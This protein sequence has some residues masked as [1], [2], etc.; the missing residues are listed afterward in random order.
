MSDTVPVLMSV[1]WQRRRSL[2][3]WSLALAAISAM[4]LSFYPSMG[5]DA[6]DDLIE[7]LPDDLV[8]ALGYDTIGTAGG[9]VTS[10]VYGLL[11][12]ALL[13]VFTIGT[14]ARLI[15]GDEEDGT[16]EL[17]VT[18]PLYRHRILAE[19]LGGLA[20][21]VLLLVTVVTGVS[22]L[23]IT[24]LSMDV[25]IDRLAAGSVGLLLL[26]LGFGAIAFGI[27]AATG[28]RSTAIG[29]A[30]AMAV[31][32]F[33]FDALGPVVDIDW[34][35]QI[36]PFFWYLG[37]DPLID[38]FDWRGLAKLSLLS[39]AGTTAAFVGFPRRDLRV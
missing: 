18:A 13:L 4:Y 20:A 6:M 25:P 30:S 33:I 3:G 12:P 28:S 29:A 34:L 11:G 5:G 9:W 14:G 16:L 36:S 39:V 17:E 38:G 23:F 35:S 15:A 24:A 1:L 37:E 10:T 21:M 22:W 32:A 27:G 8:V 31:A 7:G 26:T 19:R 2:V